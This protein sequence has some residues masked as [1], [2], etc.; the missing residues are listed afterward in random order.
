[1]TSHMSETMRTRQ[2]EISKSSGDA[3]A[4]APL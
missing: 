3:V 2:G 4:A 1:M